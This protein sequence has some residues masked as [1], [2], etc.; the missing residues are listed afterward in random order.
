MAP[1]EALYGRPCR[2]LICW[3]EVGKSSINSPNLIRDTLEKVCLIQ[4]RLLTAQSW[5]KSYANRWRRPLEFEV[6]DHVF[7]KVMPQ[8]EVVR[9]GKQGKLAPRYIGPSR[10]SRRWAQLHIGWRYHRVYQVSIRC[11]TSPC[12]INILQIQLM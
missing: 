9:F 8:R 3:T 1:Y 10:Y 4:K 6:G 2:S 5:Q 11:S 12:S 7:L